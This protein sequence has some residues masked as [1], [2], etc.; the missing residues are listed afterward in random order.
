MAFNFCFF[1][2]FA[3]FAD[4]K[5]DHGGFVCYQY[6]TRKQIPTDHFV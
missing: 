1:L 3:A 4:C 2:T 5:E 6:G